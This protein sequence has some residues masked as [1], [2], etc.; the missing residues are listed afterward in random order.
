MRSNHLPSVLKTLNRSGNPPPFDFFPGAQLRMTEPSKVIHI[1]NVGH[2]INENDLLQLVHPFG[3]VT[4][5]VIL[6]AKNQA[7]IQMQ[8]VPT[9]ASV[10]QY[11]GTVQPSISLNELQVNYNNERSRPASFSILGRGH[12]SYENARTLDE[13]GPCSIELPGLESDSLPSLF[14][15]IHRTRQASV[16][17]K[18]RREERRENKI[19]NMARP[20]RARL[21]LE[22]PESW[23]SPPFQEF[24]DDVWP[25]TSRLLRSLKYQP[26]N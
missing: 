16:S 14:R 25:S 3:A 8:D 2:E 7:L 12:H 19:M 15:G 18:K 22:E 4:K 17:D 9:A 23:P 11:Y 20:L 6:R 13:T 21:L 26:T 10:L 24:Y 5:L 1:R